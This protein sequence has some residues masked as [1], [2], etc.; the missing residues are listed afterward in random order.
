MFP[1]IVGLNHRT[2][3]IE[4][5]EKTSLHHTALRDA[6]LN[7]KNHPALQ[8]VVI[9]STCNRLEIYAATME[10]EKGVALIKAFLAAQAG[11]T[12][13]EMNRYLYTQTL[14][15]TVRHL[16]RVASGLDS[17]LLGETQII[18]QVAK[19]YEI[20]YKN[21]TTNKV[22]NVL[23]QNALTVGK[24]VRTETQIDQHPVSISYTAVE[25]ALRKFGDL[26]GK[27]IMI[28]GAGEMGRLAVKYLVEAGASTVIVS[29]RSHE[30]AIVLAEE[31]N[32]RAI[33]AEQVD[34]CLEDADI[35]ISATSSENFVLLPERI[36]A[37]MRKRQD[38]P[39]M[40]IDIAVPRDIHPAAGEIDGVTL[41]DID[42]LRG[43]V[44]RHQR[45]RELAAQ[46]SED[47]IEEE[48]QQF[49]KWHNSLFVIPT[50]VSLQQKGQEIKNAQLERALQRLGALTPRQEEI[51]RSMAN[52]IVNQL[53]HIPISNL[54]DVADTQQ[55]HLYTEILQNLFELDVEEKTKKEFWIQGKPLGS[56]RQG[57]AT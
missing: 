47:I 16:F 50:I 8:G 56:K 48:M 36:A 9:L 19:N 46:H 29:N 43:V 13:Q 51:V 52:S 20:A 28:F 22:M 11:M 37:A 54:K 27:S 21:G 34:S 49:C 7:L 30:R 35:V 26:N 39:L 57:R 42:S 12:T 31:F 40:L 23:F 18:G 4:V 38:K 45:E 6:L 10:V 53:L 1:V 32:G 5:R 25:L 55:G 44:D 17:M 41:Y 33:Q 24:R 15:D 3:P 14:Y 2:A